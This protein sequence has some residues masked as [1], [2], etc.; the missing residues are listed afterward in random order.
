MFS[1]NAEINSNNLINSINFELR[2]HLVFSEVW[3]AKSDPLD[4]YGL[5]LL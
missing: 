4:I 3:F 2:I 1:I 5:V